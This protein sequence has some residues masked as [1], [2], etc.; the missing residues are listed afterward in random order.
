MNQA[1]SGDEE[2]FNKF[3]TD[4]RSH[5][6][7]LIINEPSFINYQTEDY[8]F[9]TENN[10]WVEWVAK[11]LSCYYRPLKTFKNVKV[12]LLI[13]RVIPPDPTWNCP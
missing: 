11:P 12:E 9:G 1:M 3:Y 13:P 5:R 4:L 2:L 10:V 8:E 6:F 7:S